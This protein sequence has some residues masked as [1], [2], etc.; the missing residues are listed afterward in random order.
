LGLGVRGQSVGVVGWG[1][2][3]VEEYR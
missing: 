2:E 3:V 1:W